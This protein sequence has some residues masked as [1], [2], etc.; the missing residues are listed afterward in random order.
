MVARPRSSGKKK[1][2]FQLV[3]LTM[4]RGFL[5]WLVLSVLLVIL[6]VTTWESAAVPNWYAAVVAIVPIATACIYV[7]RIALENSNSRRPCPVEKSPSIGANESFKVPFS[8]AACEALAQKIS[9][10]YDIKSN[11]MEDADDIGVFI[12]SYDS[13][14]A[15]LNKMEQLENRVQFQNISPGYSRMRMERE[16]QWHLRDT[17]ERSKDRIIQESKSKYRNYPEKTV[18][19][20]DLFKY[21]VNKFADR[22]DSGTA[23]F[24]QKMMRELEQSC[25]VSLSDDVLTSQSRNI[26]SDSLD[27]SEYI[28]DEEKW[29]CE[30]SGLS[31]SEF[32]FLKIDAMDG[33]AFEHYCAALLQRNGFE[34]VSVTQ[35]SGDQGVDV[36]AVKD[37]VHYAIQCKCYSSPLGNTPVQEVFAGK[38]M[39][40]CQVGVVMTNNYFTQGAKALAEKTRVLLWDR[41]T[42]TSML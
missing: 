1:S 30:Q 32:E 35:G 11:L 19:E 2:K 38:E 27:V 24:A 16:F 41:D 39:Y 10:D 14:L 17:M 33:H 15:D 18:E 40:G 13:A 12:S 26:Q 22:F 8:Q 42:L 7:I 37:G 21:N 29:R 6:G 34:S 4:L 5:L 31:P 9:I 28:K 36:V 20:C 23:S 3:L 25:N